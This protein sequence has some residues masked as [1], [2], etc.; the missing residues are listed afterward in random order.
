MSRS[1][2][3][4]AWLCINRRCYCWTSFGS[5]N[6]WAKITPT[7]LA[8]WAE[9]LAAENRFEDHRAALEASIAAF[10]AGRCLGGAA[11]GAGGQL[12]AQVAPV[13]GAAGQEPAQVLEGIDGFRR[14]VVEGGGQHL[15]ATP[16]AGA[17]RQL[18]RTPALWV[19]LVASGTTTIAANTLVNAS[20]A[21][22]YRLAVESGA[23]LAVE[24]A[25]IQTSGQNVT[26]SNGGT[27]RFNAPQYFNTGGNDR[28]YIQGIG[29]DGG[30]V[31]AVKNPTSWSTTSQL[32]FT[33]HARL[34][35]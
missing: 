23:T 9:I 7:V 25:L 1:H 2:C 8:T 13:E 22:D 24:G 10:D 3:S 6:R 16:D 12:Q 27:I 30:N 21:R 20:N 5:F 17:L 26:T 14:L 28:Y 35:A 34:L 31:A 4:C 32:T 33:S 29:L 18:V 15:L 19:L 11:G